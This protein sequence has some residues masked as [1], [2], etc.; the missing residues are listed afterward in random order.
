MIFYF[1]SEANGV[2]TTEAHSLQSCA[3]ELPAQGPGFTALR[4][5]LTSEDMGF[6]S[7]V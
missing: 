1:K 7:M 5:G 6:I 2:W 4:L 3:G